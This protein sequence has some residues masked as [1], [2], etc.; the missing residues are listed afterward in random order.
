MELLKY[1]RGAGFDCTRSMASRDAR[2]LLA[3]VDLKISG[4]KNERR[5]E[6]MVVSNEA[7]KAFDKLRGG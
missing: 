6:A 4:Y 1:L 5:G 7:M 3:P 2:G